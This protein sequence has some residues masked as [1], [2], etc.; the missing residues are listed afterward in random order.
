M[1]L[2]G[3]SGWIHRHWYAKENVSYTCRA[4]YKCYRVSKCMETYKIWPFSRIIILCRVSSNEAVI[5][6]WDPY[7]SATRITLSFLRTQTSFVSHAYWS[8]MVWLLQVHPYTY[9]N[10]NQF[11][12][13]NFHQDPYAEYD[14]WI[15][16]VEVDGLFTDFCGS[17]HQYQEWVAPSRKEDKSASNVLH[18]ISH[19]I[20]S[21]K[22]GA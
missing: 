16:K 7:W 2:D 10:E 11:L 21:F 3:R 13:F 1:K 19:M 6:L 17:L 20:S 12:H 9:R 15:N 8:S 22:Q 18:R 4:T 5:L 14:Y